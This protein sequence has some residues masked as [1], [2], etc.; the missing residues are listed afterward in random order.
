MVVQPLVVLAAP[1]PVPPPPDMVVRLAAAAAAAAVGAG[2]PAAAMLDDD[3]LD[4]A[5]LVPKLWI[6]DD[7]CRTAELQLNPTGLVEDV[8]SSRTVLE[9]TTMNLKLET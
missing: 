4:E 1:V 6:W 2:D 5:D 7:R 9:P 3:D 8:D